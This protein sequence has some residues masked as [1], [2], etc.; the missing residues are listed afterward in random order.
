LAEQLAPEPPE[1]QQSATE[2]HPLAKLLYRQQMPLCRQPPFAHCELRQHG[3]PGSSPVPPQ[4]PLQ[5]AE[6][7]H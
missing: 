4:I 7:Q 6:L 3:V 5:Q 1:L 2:L